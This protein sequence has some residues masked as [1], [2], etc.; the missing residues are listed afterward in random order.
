MSIIGRVLLRAAAALC[1]FGLVSFAL[2][3]S[4]LVD[5]RVIGHWQGAIEVPGQKLE[6]DIDFA[7][8]HGELKGDISIPA[9]GAADLPAGG[10]G[11][12]QQG[13]GGG[14]SAPACGGVL[15]AAW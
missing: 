9:Q 1:A 6:Y 10:G 5:D 12:G 2:A 7:T 13:R 3:A 15:T 8:D 14:V 11:E 4:L